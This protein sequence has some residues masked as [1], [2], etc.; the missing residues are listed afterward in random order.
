MAVS[1][2]WFLMAELGEWHIAGTRQRQRQT[3]FEA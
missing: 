1:S 2:F 3:K